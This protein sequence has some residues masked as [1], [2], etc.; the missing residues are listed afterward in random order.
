VKIVEGFE[1]R[2]VMREV[3]G[4]F[5]CIPFESPYFLSFT[6]GILG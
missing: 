2:R 6:S 4:I 3:P 1:L 5:Q